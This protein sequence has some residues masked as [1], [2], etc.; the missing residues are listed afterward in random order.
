[1]G[2]MMGISFSIC[3]GTS[4]GPIV[5]RSFESFCW[6]TGGSTQNS[7]RQIPTPFYL[8]IVGPPIE[9]LATCVMRFVYLR[10]FSGTIEVNWRPN[11]SDVCWKPS[12]RP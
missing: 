7:R 9:S 1:M 3:F 2:L 4:L 5:Q 11:L 12:H 10:T 6:T 8:T